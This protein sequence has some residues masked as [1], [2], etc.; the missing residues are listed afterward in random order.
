MNIEATKRILEARKRQLVDYAAIHKDDGDSGFLKFTPEKWKDDL[1][2]LTEGVMRFAGRPYMEA[3]QDIQFGTRGWGVWVKSK[4]LLQL[5]SAAP[6]DVATLTVHESRNEYSSRQYSVSF[7]STGWWAGILDIAHEDDGSLPVLR[8]SRL[9]FYCDIPLDTVGE[10]LPFCADLDLTALSPLAFVNYDGNGNFQA[11]DGTRLARL[12]NQSGIAYGAEGIEGTYAGG[13]VN[14]HPMLV[15]LSKL[16][17][18]CTRAEYYNALFISGPLSF[19]VARYEFSVPGFHAYQPS[20]ICEVPFGDPWKFPNT[21]GLVPAW[22]DEYAK[23]LFDRAAFKK[24]VTAQKPKEK[25]EH[26]IVRLNFFHGVIHPVDASQH[27]EGR[28]ELTCAGAALGGWHG[29]PRADWADVRRHYLLD[30]LSFLKDK[31]VYLMTG[32]GHLS[33]VFLIG[34]TDEDRKVIVMP[35][36]F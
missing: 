1:V 19:K 35:F 21:Q 28:E 13:A 11:T 9:D 20:V 15:R 10:L 18:S 12:T 33:P 16:L 7:R 30:A 6:S 3:R 31:Q 36:R 14:F 25:V 24:L 34:R 8:P 5:L 29:V 27:I 26:D 4:D 2:Y 17:K 22:H 23:M 32:E